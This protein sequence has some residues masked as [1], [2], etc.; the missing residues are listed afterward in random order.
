MRIDEII[1][2]SFRVCLTITSA[3]EDSSEDSRLKVTQCFSFATMTLHEV[4]E[5]SRN[6]SNFVCLNC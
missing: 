1:T 2:N 4:A 3:L 6:Q 5:M